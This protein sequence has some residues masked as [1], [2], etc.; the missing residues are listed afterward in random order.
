MKDAI[1]KYTPIPE[2]I[3]NLRSSYNDPLT[4]PEG[5]G[6]LLGKTICIKFASAQVDLRTE[7]IQ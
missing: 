5:R 6:V 2:I 1:F 4:I 7:K 3:T